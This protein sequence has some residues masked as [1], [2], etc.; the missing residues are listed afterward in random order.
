MNTLKIT[1]AMIASVLCSLTLCAANQFVYNTESHEAGTTQI[2]YKTDA[3]GKYL[4][5]HLKYNFSYDEQNRVEQKEVSR[6]NSNSG[7]WINQ[8]ILS[9]LYEKDTYSIVSADWNAEEKVYHPISLKAIY[10]LDS[11]NRTCRYESFRIDKDTQEWELTVYNEFGTENI[12]LY[13]QN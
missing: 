11:E 7:M 3:T 10:T 8:H 5:P 4:I 9:F 1:I 13:A 6:W 2:V 12:D